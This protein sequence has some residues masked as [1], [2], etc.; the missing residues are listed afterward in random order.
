MKA[1]WLAWNE[2]F[3]KPVDRVGQRWPEDGV[4]RQTRAD[5]GDDEPSNVASRQVERDRW[6]HS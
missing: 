4:N 6:C 3:G 1:G 2:R 5:R